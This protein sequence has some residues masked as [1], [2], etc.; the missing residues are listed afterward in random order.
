MPLQS[1]LFR[2]DPQLQAAATDDQ[3]H[4]T[5]GSRGEHVRLIQRALG[6]LNVP[7]VSGLEY[8]QAVYGST[9]ASAVLS[10]KTSRNI[11]NRSYQQKA[12]NIVG[13]MTIAALDSEVVR[14]ES[15]SANS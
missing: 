8:T 9:T 2:D 4:V 3:S 1:Q 5:Q 13:K 7:G 11:I 6:Y 10:Y 15:L 12:D 14:A